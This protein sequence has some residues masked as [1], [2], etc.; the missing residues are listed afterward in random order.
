MHTRFIFFFDNVSHESERVSCV[1]SYY[2]Q[3]T[4]REGTVQKASLYKVLSKIQKTLNNTI[5]KITTITKITLR[6]YNRD[7]YKQ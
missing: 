2:Y 4:T 5:Q 3:F 6:K 7:A 1:C